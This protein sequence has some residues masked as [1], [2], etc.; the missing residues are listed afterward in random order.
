MRVFDIESEGAL[1]TVAIAKF[2]YSDNGNDAYAMLEVEENGEAGRCIAMLTAN[3]DEVLKGYSYIDSN[4]P[5]GFE[6][7]VEE[8]E[9]GKKTGILIQSGFC[10]YNLYRM[11]DDLK[12]L[13]AGEIL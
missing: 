12:N 13:K 4:N 9:L 8:N 6:R 3:L 1:L 10:E 2:E 11:C 5:Y 7:F